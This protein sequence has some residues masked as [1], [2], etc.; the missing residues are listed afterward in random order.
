[1]TALR[2]GV[3]ISDLK[4]EKI[5]LIVVNSSLKKRFNSK[6]SS[7]IPAFKSK[8]ARLETSAL[9]TVVEIRSF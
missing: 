4:N 9:R 6:K 5:K 8:I 1:M 2:T 7:I 3:T